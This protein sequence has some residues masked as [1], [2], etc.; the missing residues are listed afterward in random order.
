MPKTPATATPEADSLRNMVQTF[1]DKAKMILQAEMIS[2]KLQELFNAKASVTET[3]K[4]IKNCEKTLEV[5]NYDIK[6]LDKDH[7]YY[8]SRLET[9]EEMIKNAE[10]DIKYYKESLERC[11][12]CVTEINESITKIEAGEVKVSIERVKLYTDEMIA[13]EKLA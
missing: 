2:N 12:K 7:P 5:I 11:V 3:E 10:T 8:D 6:K 1:R 9:K 4:S 13:A